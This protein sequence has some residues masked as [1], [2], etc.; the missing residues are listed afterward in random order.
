MKKYKK[1]DQNFDEKEN[2][3]KELIEK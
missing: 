2:I 1:L 3:Y